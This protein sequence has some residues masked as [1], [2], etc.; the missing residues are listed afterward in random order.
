MGDQKPTLGNTAAFACGEK[1]PKAIHLDCRANG[2]V[3]ARAFAPLSDKLVEENKFLS[4]PSALN[5]AWQA[6][7]AVLREPLAKAN[8]C[9]NMTH[10]CFRWRKLAHVNGVPQQSVVLAADEVGRASEGCPETLRQ[11]W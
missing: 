10:V 1:H 3:R 6:E 5:R 7:R 2:S 8:R 9:R 4:P 11:K